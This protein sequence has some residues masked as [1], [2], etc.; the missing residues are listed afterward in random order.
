MPNIGPTELIL[1]LVIALFVLGPKRLPGVGRSLGSGLREFRDS[2]SGAG[3]EPQSAEHPETTPLHPGDQQGGQPPGQ[4]ASGN[5]ST[6]SQPKSSD[7]GAID[8]E[9]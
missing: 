1:V 4:P 5:G 2:I 9:R 6:P 7:M 8:I 3:E